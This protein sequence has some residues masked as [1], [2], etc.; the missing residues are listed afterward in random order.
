MCKNKYVDLQNQ[1]LLLRL[2]LETE[3]WVDNY[4]ENSTAFLLQV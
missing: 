4:S 1:K 2:R 3:I